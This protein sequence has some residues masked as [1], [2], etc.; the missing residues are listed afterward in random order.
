MQFKLVIKLKPNSLAKT[1][2]LIECYF[3]RRYQYI[4]TG[5]YTYL[6]Y[7]DD[8]RENVSNKHPQ[9]ATVNNLINSKLHELEQRANTKK[10]PES[11]LRLK[12]QKIFQRAKI[13]KVFMIL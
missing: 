4:G 3:D 11:S 8:Q 5:A 10:H 12:N 7:W 2:I 13:N 1:E 6:Q 9:A